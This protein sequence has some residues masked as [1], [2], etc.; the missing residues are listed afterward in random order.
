MGH[1]AGRAA[2]CALAGLESALRW[3]VV[4]AAALAVLVPTFRIAV[5]WYARGRIDLE[6]AGVSQ[7]PTAE[8]VE[9]LHAS[10]AEVNAVRR[11]ISALRY[12]V[13]ATNL[14]VI[15]IDDSLAP[16]QAGEYLP[17]ARVIRLR[18][19]V[20]GRGGALLS[21]AVAHEIGHYVDDRYMNEADRDLYRDWR[22]IPRSAGWLDQTL[23]WAERPSEDFA[24]VFAAVAQSQPVDAPA[25]EYGRIR[26]SAG[27]E[28]LLARSGAPLGRLVAPDGPAELAEREA[29]FFR[30][31][32]SDPVVATLLLGTALAYVLVAA[33]PPARDAWHRGRL[34]P[35]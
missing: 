29:A 25:T 10:P 11:A 26:G 5:E 28:A 31:M 34:G 15:V 24:E 20:V 19:S 18:R 22:G 7:Q 27:F 14:S 2:R 21:W 23:P 3:L 9:V 16:A 12:R 13:G 8:P 17:N 1:V 33:I 4:L 35:A 30:T 6:P 32:L